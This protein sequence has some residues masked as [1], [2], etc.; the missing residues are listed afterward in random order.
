MDPEKRVLLVYRYGNYPMRSTTAEHLFAFQKYCP[1]PIDYWN[2][3]HERGPTTSEARA[4]DLIVFHYLFLTHHWSGRRT[5]MDNCRRVSV[6]RH[7][8][9]IKVMLPQDEFYHSDLFVRFIRTFGIHGVFSV[10]P[11]SEWEKIYRGVD[12]QRVR[13]FRVLTGY[14]DEEKVRLVR[15]LAS[16]QPERNVDIGYRTAGKPCFW[17]GRHGYL[18]QRIAEVFETRGASRGLATDISTRSEDTIHGDDWYRFL[19]RCKHAI[20]VESGTSVLDW[21][22]SVCKKTERYVAR[23]P[24]AD[25]DEVEAACFPGL[26]GQVRLFA[27]SPRHLEACLT[28]TC[29]VLT[30]GDYQGVLQPNIHYV[31]IRKD[32]SD[33]DRALD[34]ICSDDHR[35]DMTDRAYRDVVAS[36]KYSY[37]RFVE[38]VTERA[39]GCFWFPAPA[40]D[41]SEFLRGAIEDAE[42]RLRNFWQKVKRRLV[43][44]PTRLPD[45]VGAAGRHARRAFGPSAK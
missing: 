34:V 18:K 1:Y 39:L 32:L 24:H 2:I 15:D 43:G 11:E 7:V 23:H 17:F 35:A 42:D 31:E 10:A 40:R 6:L 26:D 21:D 9:G 27:L 45:L 41:S 13:F 20:G 14:V 36:G 29:Q 16:L 38:C 3:E 44:S 28:R 30:Q 5:F 4:Y 25:F 12:F 8:P 33:V 22:G 19:L 37:R